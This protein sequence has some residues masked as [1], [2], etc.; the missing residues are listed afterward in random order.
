MALGQRLV[1]DLMVEIGLHL[2]EPFVAQPL[3]TPVNAGSPATLT[4]PSVD[5]LYPGAQVVA[6]WQTPAA[7]VITV[8]S[9]LPGSPQNQFTA[10]LVNNHAAADLVFGATFPTQQPTDPIF[11][12]SEIIGYI[13][14]AQNEFLTRVPLILQFLPYQLLEIGQAFQT[15]PNSVIEMERVS[16]QQNIPPS[17]TFALTSIARTDNLVQATV[18]SSVNSDQWT[19]GLAVLVAEV[20][21]TSYDSQQGAF[22]DLTLTLF[23]LVSVSPDGLTLTWEQTGANSALGPGG[24]VARPTWTRLYEASQ[25]QAQLFDPF[26]F[27]NT[28]GQAPTKWYEDRTGIYGWGVLPQPQSNYWAEILTSQRASESLTLLSSFLVPDIF[29]YAIK[30]G[31][32]CYAWSKDGVQR[33][34]TM[35]RFAKG[36]FDHYCLLADRFLRAMEAPK[37]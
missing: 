37:R 14:Q 17:Q 8:L 23:P 20:G 24:I 3:A 31:A 10:D 11:T 12:Q 27:S 21:D 25:E 9:L 16:L 18:S 30:W 29:V 2:I 28:T 33:S 5:S 15:L 22:P 7:E 13:A 19:P 6:G 1:A 32:L 34:P 4:I 26:A 36:K 35:A